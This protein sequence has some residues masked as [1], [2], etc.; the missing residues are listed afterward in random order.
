MWQW[1]HLILGALMVAAPAAC[2]RDD[3]KNADPA[4]SD[5]HSTGDS[6]T[7]S[8]TD[9]DGD[10]DGDDGSDGD[11]DGPFTDPA[12]TGSVS[13]GNGKGFAE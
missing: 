10:A 12:D 11:S 5:S 4:D 6:D 13:V 1:K 9:T 2:G 8:D 7:D 3:G